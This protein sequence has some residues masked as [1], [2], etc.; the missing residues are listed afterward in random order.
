MFLFFKYYIHEHRFRLHCSY[1]KAFRNLKKL[2]KNNKAK[3]KMYAGTS[4]AKQIGEI[5]SNPLNSINVC[6]F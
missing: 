3:R 2:L 1:N 5:A 6:T 4:S